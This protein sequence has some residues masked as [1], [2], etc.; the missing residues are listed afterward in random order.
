MS[1]GV[2]DGA[3]VGEAAAASDGGGA[4]LAGAVEA[5]GEF[6]APWQAAKTIAEVASK[7]SRRFRI[8]GPPNGV[9]P[10]T[11]NCM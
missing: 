9:D 6:V 8:C 3:T 1:T 10:V 5:D 2:G 11:P 7:P 4:A